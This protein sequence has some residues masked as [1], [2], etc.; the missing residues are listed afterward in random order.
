MFQINT[1]TKILNDQHLI[2]Q[3]LNVMLQPAG[4]RSRLQ[5][6]SLA[7]IGQAFAVE[8]AHPDLRALP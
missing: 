6:G 8:R 4:F 3:I 7:V 5:Q 1:A 2:K